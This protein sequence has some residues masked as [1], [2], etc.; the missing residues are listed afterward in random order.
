MQILVR[1]S[2]SEWL[3]NRLF[4]PQDTR[5]DHWQ[6]PLYIWKKV[7]ETRNLKIDTWDMYPLSKADLIWI[8]DLPRFKEEII[9]AR[10][11]AP[12]VPFILLH[13]ESPLDREY[14]HDYRNHELFDMIVTF[15]HHLCDERRYFHYH[16]PIGKPNSF[17][18]FKSFE[19]RK[20]LIMMNTNRYSGFL[21]P[22]LSGITG[23]PVI[24]PG[25]GGW[26]L[27]VRQ[28]LQRHRLDLYHRR[29][30]IARLAE[31]YYP[32]ILT[33]YGSGWQGEPTSWIHKIIPSKPFSCA[34][35][36]TTIP[37]LKTL[38]E[39]RFCLAFENMVGS[40][41]Y[42][43]E[44]IF[45]CFYAGVVPIYLGDKDISK[46]VPEEAFIDAR[47]FK[48]DIEILNYVKNC[49]KNV[50]EK[51]Y[52]AG[53]AYLSSKQIEKFQTDAFVIR[54]LEIIDIAMNISKPLSTY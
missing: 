25:L 40:Y 27:S 52:E 49:P 12:G 51:L 23:L 41:G 6:Y 24:G 16:L 10:K 34:V 8:Q 50:W 54:M 19:Q 14:F 48:T 39:Y 4:E 42:I 47:Q 30:R 46:Y 5:A 43:S 2:H 21:A 7:A 15:S 20:L 29:R 26:K 53:Q 1:P 31:R 28:I 38:S 13:Y 33:I 35:G 3:Q 11:T 32:D 18:L 22:R 44:K 9:A 37:K 17:P 36:Q 45:D